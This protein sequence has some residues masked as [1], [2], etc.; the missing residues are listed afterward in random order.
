MIKLSKELKEKYNEL[1]IKELIKHLKPVAKKRVKDTYKQ[2]VS[3]LFS[4]ITKNEIR[5]CISRCKI[6]E[7]EIIGTTLE[8]TV[9]IKNKN[10]IPA[11]VYTREMMNLKTYND[12][13]ISD[14]NDFP[15][16]KINKSGKCLIYNKIELEEALDG[17]SFATGKG[18]NESLEGVRFSKEYLVATDMFILY[19]TTR[20]NT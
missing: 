6:T 14:F 4:S 8:N 17:V 18:E 9:I 7:S 12:T 3:I 15:D 11:G 16:V 13:F 19:M 2:D 1:Q 5:R 10:G 20:I